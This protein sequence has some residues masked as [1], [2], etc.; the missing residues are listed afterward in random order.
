[1][2][3]EKQAEVGGREGLLREFS[4]LEKGTD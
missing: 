2:G 1:V 3:L 4:G